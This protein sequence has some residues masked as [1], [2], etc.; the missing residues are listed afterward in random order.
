M[1][2]SSIYGTDTGTKTPTNSGGFSS[3]YN[4]PVPTITP[5]QEQIA[6]TP[7]PKPSFFGNVIGGLK[8]IASDVSK[9]WS[10]PTQP[11]QNPLITENTPSVGGD[12]A[13]TTINS[14]ANSLKDV[15]NRWN[16][17]VSTF[18]D[19]NA[20]LLDKGVSAG[21]AA[22]GGLQAFFA[23][24]TAAGAGAEK[25]PVLGPIAT[26]INKVFSTIG[27]VGGDTLAQSFDSIPGLPQDIKDKAT[28]LVKEIGSL[29]AQIAVGG[30]GGDLV[31]SLGK[32]VNDFTNIIH[33]ARASIEVKN[34][35]VE[36][37]SPTSTTFETPGPKTVVPTNLSPEATP[38]KPVTYNQYGEPLDTIPA[39][40]TPKSTVEP[41]VQL[42][43]TQP[44][45]VPE[46][47]T[48]ATPKYTPE[49]KASILQETRSLFGKG[50]DYKQARDT[51]IARF[52]ARQAEPQIPSKVV[53]EPV[54]KTV[55]V[56]PQ[57]APRATQTPEMAKA[58]P[59]VE[60][61]PKTA[62]EFLAQEN[63]KTNARISTETVQKALSGASED[64]RLTDSSPKTIYRAGTGDI[65]AGD[66]VSDSK[67]VVEDYAARRPG[68]TITSTNVTGDSL[69][70]SGKQGEYVYAPKGETP[71]GLA[72]S[73][74]AKLV[75]QG[76]I[77]HANATATYEGSTIKEQAK[78]FDQT[79][80]KGIDEIRSIVRGEK[81]LPEG[82]KPLSFI[83]NT[84]AYLRDHPNFDLAQELINSPLVSATSESASNLGLGQNRIQDSFTAKA[85]EI[86]KAREIRGKATPE[87]R[88]TLKKQ[89]RTAMEKVNVSEA[90][91][92]KIN[93]FIRDN[94]C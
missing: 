69:I 13:A 14:Y 58:T 90:E 85:R 3:I 93:K 18:N 4:K 77:E 27:T 55:P 63:R 11:V 86:Q 80:S 5:A 92:G 33:G 64:K 34:V 17:M 68:T 73:I 41:S 21:E 44:K 70:K 32:K 51:A 66:F 89:A 25:I 88:A 20:S 75:E 65:K 74:E 31:E 57:E 79:A 42:G 29:G 62:S 76:T 61:T 26:G 45:V 37:Q 15:G 59:T 12:I 82:G 60:T 7:T 1:S 23:P 24:L 30:K 40:P 84:E 72:R 35:P 16:N 83:V 46:V 2:F 78:I 9:V 94:L 50:M 10:E 87:Q 6:P 53:P 49:Q 67:K 38:I 47:A 36:N 48:E 22:M 81:P 43:E 52:N 54:S 8:T 56:S 39:G 71:S 28:P 19:T 91:L